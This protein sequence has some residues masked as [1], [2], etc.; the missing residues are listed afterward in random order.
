FNLFTPVLGALLSFAFSKYYI[1]NS[2]NKEIVRVRNLLGA[3]LAPRKLDEVIKQKD[4][5]EAL[6]GERRVVTVLFADIAGFTLLSERMPTY[7]V[8]RILNEF[9]THMTDIIFRNEGTLDKYT[10]DGVMAVFGNIGKV[11]VELNV[12]RAV[13]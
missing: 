2:R 7:E 11:E 10:G 12:F 3:N 4:Y 13:K 5:I 8:V 6:K 9:L 1:F